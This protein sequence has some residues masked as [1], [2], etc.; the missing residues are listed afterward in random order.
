MP[1]VELATVLRDALHMAHWIL[2]GTMA[3]VTDAIANREPGG[4]ANPIGACYMHVLFTEDGLLNRPKVRAQPP[5]F[6]SSWSDRTGADQLE[7]KW[8]QGDLGAWY[9]S[10]KV[11]IGRAREYG[12]AVFQMSEEYVGR[13]SGSDLA[14]EIDSGPLGNISLAAW[15]EIF[16][17]GH[18]NTLTGEISAVKGMFGLKGYPF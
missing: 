8:G 5:L 1:D 11:D 15:I 3:D 6:E 17:T 2:D 14:R 4:K 10:V 7:P 12:Q 9:H 18:T 16:L 13:L